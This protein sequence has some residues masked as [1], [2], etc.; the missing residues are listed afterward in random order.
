MRAYASELPPPSPAHFFGRVP[1]SDDVVIRWTEMI[2]YFERLRAF[3]D[4]LAIETIGHDHAGLPLLLLTI[5]TDDSKETR[6]NVAITAGVH[7]HE[8]GGGQLMPDLV[9]DLLTA[10]DSATRVML[11][12]VTLLIVPCIN[13]S[14]L[15]M[16]ADW[17]ARTDG[18]IFSG[19]HPPGQ[20][21]PIG[22]DLNRD[23]IVQTQPEI[24]V[25]VERIFNRWRPRIVL[26]LHEMAPNGPRYALPPS[27]QPVD[28]NIPPEIE[29]EAGRIGA[30]IASALHD[31]GKAGVT[32]G[33]FF[34]SFSPARS[35][36]P[37]HGGT[38]V[39]A[40]A[41]GTRLGRPL[42]LSTDELAGALDFDPRI[43]SERHRDVWHGGRWSLADVGAYHR[44]AIETTLHFAA[45]EATR[46]S[47]SEPNSGSDRE[48]GFVILPIAMQPD[49]AAA[50][51]L[52]ATL[53]SGGINVHRLRS[54]INHRE[55]EIPAESLLVRSV[56]PN[57]PW[58]KSLL[59]VQH[60]VM[61]EDR[62]NRFPYDV[63]AQTLPL[64][65]GVD[66]IAI[67]QL[68]VLDAADVPA[69]TVSPPPFGKPRTA[70]YRSWRPDASEAGWAIT[71]LR[72]AGV[73]TTVLVDADLRH[74]D[75]NPFDVIVLPHQE[76]E[77]L[78]NGLNLADYPP[79]L[80]GGVGHAGMA[81]LRRWVSHGGTLIAIDGA[82]RAIIPAMNLPVE[83]TPRDYLAPGSI[84][85][86]ELDLASDIAQGCERELAVMSLTSAAFNIDR[87]GTAGVAALARFPKDDPLLSG[88]LG[89]W[90]GLAGQAAIVERRI[91]HGR[92]L[93]FGFRPLFRGQSLAS[94]RLVLNA[95]RRHARKTARS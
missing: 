4:R 16:I 82:A 52:I 33:L 35:Y 30:A 22:H 38:R 13:P 7:A 60:Y 51:T 54:A 95:I 67:D 6:T 77:H 68:P 47:P 72:D 43:P 42:Y 86:I 59:E 83:V 57:W 40:E 65:M 18:T 45:N 94:R 89:N 2:A 41:A 9:F 70:V 37:Y 11:D 5:G 32:T 46:P 27:V 3:D 93:L 78:L 24:R 1:L 29:A 66:V 92:A 91:G 85:R 10:H 26:D 61:P 15:E 69:I 34:D 75:L 39:L 12:R 20:T 84:L 64:L 36:P 80:T 90:Q 31:H 88:W 79:E 28:P 53:Q 73:E 71:M 56:Q 48:S 8:L 23:W 49:P 14:G 74:S 87:A 81:R 17:R 19:S 44:V 58:A 25:V 63:T 21:H 50:R 76:P 55:I 62:S